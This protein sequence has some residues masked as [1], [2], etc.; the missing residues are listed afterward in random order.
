MLYNLN[1]SQVGSF[2]SRVA[3][4]LFIKNIAESASRFKNGSPFVCSL[5]SSIAYF[6]VIV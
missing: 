6:N 4:V 2:S 3:L 5:K 1:V